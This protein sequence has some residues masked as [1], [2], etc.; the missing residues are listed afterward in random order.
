MRAA[1]EQ[2]IVVGT[3]VGLYGVRGWVR[4]MSHT[5]PRDNMLRYGQWHLGRNG[6]WRPAELEEGKVHG[7][8]LVIKLQECSDRELARQLIGTEIAVPRSELEPAKD[9]EYYWA[10]L[11]GLR[12]ETVEGQPLGVVSHLLETG[13][14]DVLVAQADDRERLIPF[15]TGQ[16]VKQVDLAAGLIQV[17]WDPD[18]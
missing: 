18:F 12:V 8:G 7:K 5:Q 17:D 10:D 14:N 15:V 6:N 16:V 4:V 1:G 11:I 13:A 9:G 2:L 3:I